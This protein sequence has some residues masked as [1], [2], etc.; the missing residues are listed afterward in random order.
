ML[1]CSLALYVS[2]VPCVTPSHGG[3]IWQ[4]LAYKFLTDI[5]QAFLGIPGLLNSFSTVLILLFPVMWFKFLRF[6][7][8]LD[9]LF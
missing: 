1:H 7:G 9:R 4:L 6:S 5:S 8:I 3:Y 2:I